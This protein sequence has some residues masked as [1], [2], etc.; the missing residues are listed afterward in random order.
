VAGDAAQQPS[1]AAQPDPDP[2]G[3]PAGHPAA[4]APPS[5]DTA[6]AQEGAF[7]DVVN[8][9]V[10]NVEVVVTERRTGEPVVG[11]TRDD[12]ELFEDGREVAIT[13]FYA[14][15]E[16]DAQARRPSLPAP[17]GAPQPE[18]VPEEQ[19][20]YVVV[21]IDNFNIRPFNRNRVFMRL[22]E[23]LNANVGPED[24]VMLGAFNRTFKQRVAFT[25]DPRVINAELFEMEDETGFGVHRDSERRQLL[26]EIEQAEDANQIIGSVRAYAG[27]YYNDTMVT[28]DGLKDLVASLGGLPGRKALLYVSD[29]VPQTPAEDM[30]YLLQEKFQGAGLLLTS[31][32]FDASRRFTELANQAN[33]NRVTFYT[34]DAGGLRTMTSASAEVATPGASAF[35]DS[36]NLHNLQEPLTRL[37]EATGG[38]AILNTN[39]VGDGL[40]NVARDLRTYYSLGYQP[41]HQGDGRYHRIEVKTKRRGL[42]VRH[43]SGYRDKSTE[44]RMADATT[45]ALRFGELDNPLGVALQFGSMSRRDDGNVLVPIHLSIPLDKVTLLPQAGEQVARLRVFIAAADTEG[46]MSPVQNTPLPLTIPTADLE[47]ARRKGWG[48]D[49]SLLMRPGQHRVSVGVRDELGGVSSY[50]TGSVFVRSR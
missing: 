37:A 23:W 18:A 50:V 45:A 3:D 34:I 29:G 32:E 10:V 36:Q 12:F 7:I 8:V 38:R 41:A 19:R 13:N 2:A 30:F 4:T 46:G 49:V 40:R 47:E 48:Y 14:E 25:S 15:Q 17:P 28:I 11:L 26:E 27:S 22:R 31:R 39:D 5:Q 43:R 20:L 1:P 44:Q 33:A 42:V 21:Y 9:E 16:S 6:T 35:V 24:R